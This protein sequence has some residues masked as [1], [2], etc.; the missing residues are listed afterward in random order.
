MMTLSFI[1]AAYTLHRELK[2]KEAQGLIQPHIRTHI[3]GKPAGIQELT[4]S[5]LWGFILGFKLPYVI[6]EYNQFSNNPQEF[7]LSNKGNLIGGLIGGGIIAGLKY[8]EKK[9][10][11]L[12]QPKEEKETVYPHKM[13]GDITIVAAMS[14]LLG[15]KLFDNLE[16]WND[17]IQDPVGALFSFSGLTFYGGLIFGSVAVLYYAT[18]LGIRYYYMI[19]AAAPGLILAYAIGR[20][21]CHLSGDGDWGIVNTTGKPSW[22]SFLPDWAWSYTYPHN[23]LNEGVPIPGCEG[24]FC[25]Q[26]PEAVYPTPLYEIMW[27]SL[28]FVILWNIRKRISI[29]GILF[30]IYLVLNGMERFTIEIIRV[31]PQYEVLGIALSQA[32]L[33][34]LGLILSGCVGLWFFYTKR[35][36]HLGNPVK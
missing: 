10:H 34:A 31:N 25:F 6:L 21:G 22:L 33:I 11:Q 26:L 3:I 28:I 36:Q 30:S 18:K 35:H 15:A 17:F 9:K 1:A 20:G 14:G 16:H 29:P 23:V 24:R 32:Q 7:I 4:L 13:V 27:A 8:W 19:D 12:P 2:R 5:F